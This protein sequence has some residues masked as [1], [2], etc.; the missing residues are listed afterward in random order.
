MRL[1]LSGN[2]VILVSPLL[3]VKIETFTVDP[4]GYCRHGREV[5][6]TPVYVRGVRISSCGKSGGITPI[7]L[8]PFVPEI[9]GL[10]VLSDPLIVQ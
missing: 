2:P 6:G 10:E 4:V 9:R 3:S 8:S 5:R 7:L 1:S